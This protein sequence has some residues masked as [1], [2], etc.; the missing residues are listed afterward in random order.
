MNFQEKSMIQLRNRVSGALS[1][2][3][4]LAL[5]LSAQSQTQQSELLPLPLDEVRMFTEALDRI[6]MAYVEE[7]DDKTLL[8]NAIKGMLS[9]LDPHSAYLGRARI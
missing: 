6:R 3:L 2:C 8:E 1:I 5:P 9:G 7:I 4:L